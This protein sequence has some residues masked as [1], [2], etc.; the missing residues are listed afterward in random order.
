MNERDILGLGII[1]SIGGFFM[2]FMETPLLTGMG[3]II[4]CVGFPTAIVGG[5]KMYNET[6][7]VNKKSDEEEALSILK[8]R[9]VK[10]EI[11][12]EEYEEM[13]IAIKD[14]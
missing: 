13:K 14:E 6:N 11:T 1:L 12:K 5:I 8:S 3:F 10:G 7:R 9:Y 4:L 2:L